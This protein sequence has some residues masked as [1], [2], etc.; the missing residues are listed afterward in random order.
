MMK[1]PI[2]TGAALL[3][4]L[5][6]GCRPNSG[7]PPPNPASVSP[8][9]VARCTELLDG[10]IRNI[11]KRNSIGGQLHVMVNM[12][13]QQLVGTGTYLEQGAADTRLLRFELSIRTGSETGTFLNICDGQHIWSFTELASDR[14]LSQ[15]DLTRIAPALRD[16]RS[17]Y[18]EGIVT[19]WR[20]LVGLGMMLRR[21]QDTFVFCEVQ[22]D[23]L[24]QVPMWKLRGSWRPE[25]LVRFLPGQQQAIQQGK[26]ADFSK[27][28]PQIPDGV[29]IYLGQEDLFPYRLEY[30]RY[31]RPKVRASLLP[32]SATDTLML[33][34]QWSDVSINVPLPLAHFSYNPG[35]QKPTDTT[36]MVMAAFGLQPP[37]APPPP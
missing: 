2:L 24:R 14:Y 37:K 11:R 13:G 31:V 29:V 33:A 27:L 30:H 36:S 23:E 32:A 28:G 20:E 6:A 5:A 25:W 10:S 4:C 15:I 18:P 35:N 34:F 8:A 16:N 12:L 9:V 3:G 17:N 1:L 19:I 7:P 22:P 21:I 26:P